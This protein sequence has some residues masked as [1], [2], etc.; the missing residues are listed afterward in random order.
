MLVQRRDG[1]LLVAT[2][3][4]LLSQRDQLVALAVAMRFPL[5]TNFASSPKL[6]A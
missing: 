3:P 5:F 4:F 1:G 6:A 2:D